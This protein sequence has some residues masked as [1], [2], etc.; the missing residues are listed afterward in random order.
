MTAQL[1][2]NIVATLEGQNNN[3]KSNV[4]CKKNLKSAKGWT[5]HWLEWS[6]ENCKN[7][8]SKEPRQIEI[9][10]KH[11]VY[12]HKERFSKFPTIQKKTN[13][14]TTTSRQSPSWCSWL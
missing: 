3:K 6:H 4:V 14:Q 12:A 7:K 11:S 5:T 13:K 10:E 1:I 9:V 2:R 8:K